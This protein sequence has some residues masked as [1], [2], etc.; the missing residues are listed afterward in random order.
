MSYDKPRVLVI[1]DDKGFLDMIYKYLSKFFKVA[2]SQSSTEALSNLILKRF[3][4]VVTDIN[5]PQ[6]D[7]IE[8]IRELKKIVPKQPVIVVTG[9]PS[10][11]YQKELLSMGVQ[12]IL[13]KP[14]PL[15]RLKE[16]IDTILNSHDKGVS[17]VVDI[18]LPLLLQI[19][20]FEKKDALIQISSEEGEGKIYIKGG[21][22]VKSYL[23]NIEGF[24]A[25]V[26]ILSLDSYV[27]NQV[28]YEEVEGDINIELQKA[29][30]KAMK[31]IDEKES[32]IKKDKEGKMNVQKLKEAIEFLKKEL[33]RGL[34]RTGIVSTADGQVIV[35]DNINPKAAALF[36]RITGYMKVSLKE[37]GF[38]PLR[39]FY[40]VDLTQDKMLVV[41]PMGKYQWGVFLDTKE[42]QL[43]LFLNIVLPKMISAFEEA[44]TS[45]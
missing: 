15:K 35:G 4:V 37:S 25:F 32:V 18:D 19:L 31:V 16:C 30:M 2:V 41:I 5:M 33:G 42:V 12:Y 14:F 34:V 38:P 6:M 11:M 39:R 20:S 9:F 7:G 43:G 26:K 29:L 24:E 8:M 27:Y 22:L 17:G 10:L 1:D 13:E 36:N 21:V 23:N 44:I 40:M 3:D 45:D 28:P